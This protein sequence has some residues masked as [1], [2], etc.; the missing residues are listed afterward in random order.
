[1]QRD[2]RWSNSIFSYLWNDEEAEIYVR[3]IQSSMLN[4]SK[5]VIGPQPTSKQQQQQQ[6]QATSNK[7]MMF[8]K[9][10]EFWLE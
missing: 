5:V 6:Q 3:T 9:R 1:M 2:R 10:F 7:L 4:A 8:H